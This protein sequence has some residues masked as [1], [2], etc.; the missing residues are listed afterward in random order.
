MPPPASPESAPLPNRPQPRKNTGLRSLHGLTA[1]F[2]PQAQS[3]FGLLQLRFQHLRSS[4]CRQKA[5]DL[6]RLFQPGSRIPSIQ[7]RNGRMER[8]MLNWQRAALPQRSPPAAPEPVGRVSRCRWIVPGTANVCPAA[9]F[10]P[11]ST[12]TVPASSVRDRQRCPPVG[13]PYRQPG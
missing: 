2:G 13:S 7:G 3:L 11:L 10:S 8:L 12:T 5:R 4:P 6:L 9:T 1:A